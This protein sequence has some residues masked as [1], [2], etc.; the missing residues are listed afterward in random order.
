MS[1]NMNLVEHVRRNKNGLT[2]MQIQIPIST[3]AGMAALSARLGISQLAVVR[4]ALAAYLLQHRRPHWSPQGDAEAQRQ[5][6]HPR[7]APS[8]RTTSQHRGPA[9]EATVAQHRSRPLHPHRRQL[10][11]PMPHG[12]HGIVLSCCRVS[13]RRP[14]SHVLRSETG[15]TDHHGA[16]AMTIVTSSRRPWR[17][18]RQP[19]PSGGLPLEPAGSLPR[20]SWSPWD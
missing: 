15:N 20:T 9:E 5:P 3:R 13:P 7:P 2:K 10:P 1:D 11:K 16:T 6:P 8:P 17:K 14:R 18:P 12:L 4:S 19:R